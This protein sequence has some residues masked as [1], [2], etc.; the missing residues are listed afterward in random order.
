M[1]LFEILYKDV[2]PI[3][4]DLTKTIIDY[5]IKMFKSI[6]IAKDKSMAKRIIIQEFGSESFEI[7]HIVEL[8]LEENIGVLSTE[9]YY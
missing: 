4:S 5:E 7:I 9:L 8:K 6:A 2:V 1:K 3:K